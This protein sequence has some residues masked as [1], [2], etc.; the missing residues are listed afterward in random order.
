[1]IDLIQLQRRVQSRVP[2][3]MM[4]LEAEHL[5]KALAAGSPILTFEQ[6]PIDWSDLR[7]LVRSTADAMRTHEAIDAEDYRRVEALSRDAEKLAP[8]MRS[9]FLTA[10]PAPAGGS[11]VP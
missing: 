11:D 5:D 10:R 8:A 7:F 2:L 4:N 6:V 1:Q 9:W 3:P